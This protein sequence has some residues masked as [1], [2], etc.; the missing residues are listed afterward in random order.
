MLEDGEAKRE[1]ELA[2]KRQQAAA[3]YLMRSDIEK[4]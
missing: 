1:R 2:L 4:A 3:C